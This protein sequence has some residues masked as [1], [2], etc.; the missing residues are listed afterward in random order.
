AIRV[1]WA[2]FR[3]EAPEL[4]D[5]VAVL[6]RGG[7]ILIFPEAQLRR[8]EDQLLR[9]F[10]QGVWRILQELPETPV[11]LCWIEGGWGSFTSY[12]H[13]PPLRGKGLDWRRHIDIAVD[14][15]QVLDPGILADQHST[16]QYLMRAC[17]ECRRYLGLPVLSA[18]DPK[19][20]NY[21][22]KI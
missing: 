8:R 15:P 19:T 11:L 18:E 12:F 4:T 14:A 10:G 21:T 1:P 2:S 16:R 20:T 9:M 13:G 17:L 7:C 22:K 6:R 3:R 5:A